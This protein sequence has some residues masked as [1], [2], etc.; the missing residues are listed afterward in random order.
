MSVTDT[1]LARYGFEWSVVPYRIVHTA[2]QQ[3]VQYGPHFD[4]SEECLKAQAAKPRLKR[5][6]FT[7]ASNSLA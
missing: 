6:L 1:I 3:V 7:R 5:C 2:S 4:L